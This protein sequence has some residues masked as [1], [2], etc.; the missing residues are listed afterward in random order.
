MIHELLPFAFYMVCVIGIFGS[1]IVISYKWVLV[2]VLVVISTIKGDI[3]V[4]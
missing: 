1:K 3:R 2:I 4:Y